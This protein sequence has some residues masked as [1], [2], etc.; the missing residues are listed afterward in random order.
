MKKILHLSILAAALVA[1]AACGGGKK[2]EVVAKTLWDLTPTQT[3]V[4]GY[5]SGVLEVVEGSYQFERVKMD[6]TIQVKIKSVGKGNAADPALNDGNGGP[7][8]LAICDSLGKPIPGYEDIWNNYEGDALIKDMIRKAGNENWITFSMMLYGKKALPDHASKFYVYSKSNESSGSSASVVTGSAEWD[9][10]LNEFEQYV[11]QY[12]AAVKKAASGKTAAALRECNS[13]FE[14]AES[15][16]ERLDAAKD[17]NVSGAQATRLANILSKLSDA[18]MQMLD[19]EGL[20][21]EDDSDD[22]DEDW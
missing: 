6:A 10:L 22:D 11:T 4:K 15:L 16:G 20:G 2:K 9:K 14:K 19:L 5:L 8:Y 12:A 3:E 1:F 18:Q 13:L 7:L 21:D 17:S